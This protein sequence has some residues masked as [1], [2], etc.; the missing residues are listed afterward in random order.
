M[1]NLLFEPLK[2]PNGSTIP[3]RLKAL[4]TMLL[5]K[6]QHERKAKGKPSG[7]GRAA[8]Y[9]AAERSNARQQTREEISQV[10]GMPSGLSSNMRHSGVTV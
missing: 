4:A 2:L 1:T 5:T 8:F 6:V 9:R 3:N 10:A 7:D